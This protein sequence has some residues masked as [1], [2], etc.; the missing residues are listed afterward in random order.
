MRRNFMTGLAILLPIVITYML[1]MFFVRLLTNPFVGI[2]EYLFHQMGWVKAPET[3]KFVSQMLILLFLFSFTLLVG[4][5]G[6]L[7]L[8]RSLLNLGDAL[9]QKIP[10]V[11][12]IYKAIQDVVN[13]IFSSEKSS[14]SSV[15]LVPFPQPQSY[16]IGFVTQTQNKK[17]AVSVFVPGTPNP[18]MGFMLSFK[19]NEV[20][21]LDMDVQKALKFVVSGGMIHD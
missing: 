3:L 21:P 4:F 6:R 16:S 9:L 12:K 11:S 7:F 17:D 2:V 10:I 18:S 14:F 13:S 5:I 15:V 20:I 8:I 1:V 19:Q